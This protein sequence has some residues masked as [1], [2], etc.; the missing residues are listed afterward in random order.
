MKKGAIMNKIKTLLLLLL[1]LIIVVGCSKKTEEVETIVPD[2]PIALDKESESMKDRDEESKEEK[3]TDNG[4]VNKEIEAAPLPQSLSELAALPAGYTGPYLSALDLGDQQEIDELTKD[5]PDISNNPTENELNEFYNQYLAIFQQGFLGPEELIAKMK[6]QAIGSP[7]I[8]NPRMQFKE[9]LNV[10]VIL[11]ASGSMGKDI[12]GQTQMAAAKKAIINFVEGLPKEA[13]VGL[14]IYGHKGT[15]SSSDKEM[16]CSSSDLIY[17]LSPFENTSFK[18][19][20]DQ[21]NP[22]GWTPTELAL[23]EAGKDLAGLNGEQNTNIVYLVSDGISTCDDDPVAAAKDL[24]NSDIT[25]IV[26]VIGFNVDHDGQRQLKEVAKAVKG[27]YQDVQNAETLQ[28]ELNQ[29]NEVAKNWSKWKTSQGNSLKY[30]HTDNKLEIF[31]Y[32]S[33]EFRKRVDEGSRVGLTVQYLYLTKKVMSRESHDYLRERNRK[34]HEW[35]TEE[36]VELKK[37]LKNMNE[38]QFGE[39]IQAL[40][41]KYIENVPN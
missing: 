35:I 6:F 32:D 40:E 2:K 26:N 31:M 29:A 17:P 9:N 11:D 4:E 13:N 14:R 8:D 27:S 25:P 41:E 23:R 28:E 16:S 30:A 12:G 5:L 3:N 15:G 18:A 1:I 36:Y 20:L 10:L 38:M 33:K 24:Y 39:A 22:A 7:N 19:S 34:Y 37:E 21:V